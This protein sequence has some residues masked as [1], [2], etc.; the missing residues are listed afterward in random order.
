MSRGLLV[1]RTD[2]RDKWLGGLEEREEGGGG[3]G[4]EER[5]GCQGGG[6]GLVEREIGITEEREG[7][8]GWQREKI[9]GGEN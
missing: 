7:V 6:G 8:G 5:G 1:A 9:W 3:L 4:T 2:P